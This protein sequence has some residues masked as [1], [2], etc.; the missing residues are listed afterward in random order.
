MHKERILVVED[1]VIIALDIQ[2]TLIKMGFDVPE[3]VTSAESA[4]ERVAAAQPDLV[5]MDIHLNGAMDGIAAADEI[6]RRYRLPVVYL[7]A[8]SD[9][10]TVNRAKFT[11]PYGYVLKPFEERELQIAIDMAL[12]RHRAEI[13]LKQMEHWLR[14]TLTSIGDG[15]I[16]TDIGGT[17]T[18]MNR[19][20]EVLTGW[21]QAEALERP[22]GEVL[23]LIHTATRTGVGNLLERVLKN[24]L[25]I[26]LSPDTALIDREGTEVPVDKSAAPIRDENDNVI[27]VVIVFRELSARKYVEEKLRHFAAHDVLTGL[28]NEVLLADRLSMAFERAKRYPDYVFAL[29]YIDLDRFRLI[30]DRHGDVFGDQVLAAVAQRLRENLPQVDTLARIGGD[31]FVVIL[32]RI[33][34]PLDAVH[35]A[36]RIQR[37]MADAVNIDG[38]ETFI[39]VSIGIVLSES[40]YQRME[41]I[42]H[43]GAYALRQAKMQESSHLR[44]FN[45]AQHE[46]SMQLMQ[47]EA[48]LRLAV[49][50]KEFRIFYQPIFELAGGGVHSLEALL[51]WQHPEYGLLTPADFLPLAEKAGILVKISEW[52]LNESCRQLKAWQ[53]LSSAKSALSVSVNLSKTQFEH[54][55]LRH[56][57]ARALAAAGLEA[58]F[59]SLEVTEEVIADQAAAMP[60]LE[61]LAELGV[62]LHLDDFGAGQT[63]LSLLQNPQIHAVKVDRSAIQSLTDG[64]HDK[65][66][67]VRAILALASEGGKKVTAEGV[68]T[69]GQA[70]RLQEWGSHYGQG[71]H[72]AQPLPAEGVEQ[73]L[74]RGVNN[75]TG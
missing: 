72:F 15:V 19:M 54:P 37:K 60:I 9:E 10:A 25:I 69:A 22:L 2:R 5:L 4:L 18:Y 39:S 57:I 17:I 44:V 47:F 46:L 73:W 3:F 59:L 71:Y 32:D 45:T 66:A 67:V 30:N 21:P 74:T 24:G 35:V 16:A 6:R 26:D 62:Q 51:R 50:R 55:K 8:H 64:P 40:H 36:K 29:L 63:A 42:L 11:E 28:P 41:D 53:Q 13:K 34:D 75:L 61:G 49:E 33:E 12:Y 56:L 68:E 52:I 1:E 65:S 38:K 7:T 43:D 31:E 48:E 23:R 14:K 58:R 70:G 27:G 20:A